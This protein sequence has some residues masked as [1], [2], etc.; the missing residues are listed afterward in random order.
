MKKHPWGILASLACLL[1]G[2]VTVSCTK[3]EITEEQARIV[4]ENAE[5]V[6]DNVS[7]IYE[8]SETVE[9]M[10]Q[11]LDEIKAMENVE[12]VRLC[13]S[14]ILIKIKDGG[15]LSY[16]FFPDWGSTDGELAM[17]IG[18]F[19]QINNYA[20]K[21]DA[22]L[23]ENRSLCVV[24]AVPYDENVNFIKAD[25]DDVANKLRDIGFNIRYVTGE[26]VDVD[27]ICNEMP[28]YG[29]VI[30]QAHGEYEDG[31]H[32]IVTGSSSGLSYGLWSFQYFR[33]WLSDFRRVSISKERRNGN[34]DDYHYWKVSES[35]INDNMEKHF[36]NNSIM[37]AISCSLL[38]ANSNLWNILRKNNL[39]CFL[40]YDRPV[41]A[42][43]GSLALSSFMNYMCNGKTASEAYQS[44]PLSGLHDNF[45][46]AN[47]VLCPEDC[48]ITLV[49][50]PDDEGDWVDL[51]LPSGLLWATRNVGATSPEDYGDYFAWGETS[52]KSVYD[53]STYRY[54]NGDYDQLTKYCSLSSYGYYGFTDNLTILQP[55]DDAAT[56]NY[57]GRTPTEEEWRELM[58]HTTSQWTTQN[59]VNG[60]RFT[61][62]NG[63]S[64]FLPAAGVRWYSS[65]YY[66]G[67]RGYYWSSSLDTGYP[68]VAW[69]FYFGSDNLGMGGEGRGYGFTVR[70][71]R[72][73]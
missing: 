21:D 64:L 3:D 48:A 27:F 72:Q 8:T 39:G 1:F 57:G 28:N 45:T 65:L 50:R 22:V 25:L 70:A 4:F 41:R 34:E 9:E 12:D 33:E 7:Q 11:H 20:A 60:C 23:C 40:G 71:V 49:E 43:V 54:C 14:S 53:W 51:G 63:N 73:N 36:P 44:V 2:L 31:Q 10:A 62:S 68:D 29:V 69:D 58:D 61:G 15:I 67:I 37:F 24:N 42:E 18:N 6:M 5:V 30:I 13:D 35:Y 56:A 16:E 17:K 26:D 32:W 47:L 52:P 55:S 59:G 19:N 38:E 46:G 66:D